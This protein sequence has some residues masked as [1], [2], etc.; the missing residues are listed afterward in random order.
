MHRFYLPTVPCESGDFPLPR[1]DAKKILRVLKLDQGEEILLWD[2]EGREYL[3]QITKTERMSV[4]VRV[5]EEHVK[6]V[7]SPLRLVLVQGIPKGGKFEFII[8]KATELGV[9]SIYPAI[10]ERTVVKLPPERRDNRLRRWQ[11]VAQ[12]AARQCGRVQIPEIMPV[13]S[14]AEIL[15]NI[16]AD[17]HRLIL[18]EGETEEN[19]LKEYLRKHTETQQTPVYLFIGPEGGLSVQEVKLAQS[20]GCV[21]VTLGPRILRTETAGLVGLSLILYEWSDLGG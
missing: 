21:A 13:A 19:S 11:T 4:Y 16:E 18:W 7:E 10:T 8:Q 5:L 20:Y 12:E 9:C 3:A 15:K 1:G 6:E 14:F 2:E 17:A